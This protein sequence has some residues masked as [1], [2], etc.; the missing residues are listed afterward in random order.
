MIDMVWLTMFRILS[1]R[2]GRRKAFLPFLIYLP[3]EFG[4]INEIMEKYIQIA[5]DHDVEHAFGFITPIDNGKRCIFEYDY[6]Y[7]YN[8]KDEVNRLRAAA[9]E[10]NQVIDEYSV[11]KGTARGHPYV[12]YQGFARKENL[13]YG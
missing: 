13:L 11:N 6:F 2:V 9:Q 4:L 7:D 3:V 1:T 12:L 5:K 10:V 8:D